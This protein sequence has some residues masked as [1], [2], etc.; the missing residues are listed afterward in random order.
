[1]EF[2]RKRLMTFCASPTHDPISLL[3]A[4]YRETIACGRC[5]ATRVPDEIFVG[6][7][8]NVIQMMEKVSNNYELSI[9][10]SKHIACKSRKIIEQICLSSFILHFQS[11]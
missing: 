1:M 7:R 3:E 8:I 10:L 6:W 2:W 9:V 4:I 11:F 5:S